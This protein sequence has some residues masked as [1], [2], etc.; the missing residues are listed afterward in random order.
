MLNCKGVFFFWFSVKI[1][2]YD[3][4]YVHISYV[5]MCVLLIRLDNYERNKEQ[6]RTSAE[7]SSS[8]KMM[9]NLG[10]GISCSIIFRTS[11]VLVQ[12]HIHIHIHIHL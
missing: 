10:L 3:S 1:C 2:D 12:I 5:C 7:I 4:S 9:I 11:L 8:N 6:K